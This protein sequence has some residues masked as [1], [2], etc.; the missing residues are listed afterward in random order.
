MKLKLKTD[1]YIAQKWVVKAIESCEDILQ[2]VAARRLIKNYREL[3]GLNLIDDLCLE[4][5]MK[6][7]EKEN[8][9]MN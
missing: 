7:V 6:F 1:K 4:L 2:L 8:E 9:L 5:R 3:Y